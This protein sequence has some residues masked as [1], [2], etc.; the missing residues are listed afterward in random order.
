MSP[1]ETKRSQWTAF[2]DAV[3]VHIAK[4][5]VPVYMVEKPSVHTHAENVRPQVCAMKPQWGMMSQ[6]RG[7]RHARP[8][9][10]KYVK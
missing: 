3:T 10:Q 2:T 7:G 8:P 4:D 5:I 6:A 1:Y 9:G